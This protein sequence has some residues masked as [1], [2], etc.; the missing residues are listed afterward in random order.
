[1]RVHF[2]SETIQR[3]LKLIELKGS[4]TVLDPTALR[5]KYDAVVQL[6]EFAALYIY[7]LVG[8]KPTTYWRID[9]L[10]SAGRG[11]LALCALLLFMNN[12]DIARA[13]SAFARLTALPSAA[14]GT[15]GNV[16]G[17]NPFHDYEAWQ[18]LHEAR[19]VA[20]RRTDARP[21]AEQIDA[22]KTELHTAHLGWLA[23][24]KPH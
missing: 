4:A 2:R 11:L 16:M 15:E 3:A 23:K 21:V 5:E 8:T 13:S 22:I 6:S 1:M 10:K 19:Q 9:G 18:I 17:L 24:A 20:A 7:H 14:D 12:W